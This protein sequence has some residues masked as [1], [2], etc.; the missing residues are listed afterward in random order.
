MKTGARDLEQSAITPASILTNPTC[1]SATLD[2]RSCRTHAPVC[3]VVSHGSNN[4]LYTEQNLLVWFIRLD[5]FFVQSGWIY[6][7]EVLNQM[8]LSYRFNKGIFLRYFKLKSMHEKV[9]CYLPMSQHMYASSLF[10]T[11]HSLSALHYT[12]KFIFLLPNIISTLCAW[13]EFKITSFF[14]LWVCNA[15]RCVLIHKPENVFMMSQ[16]IIPL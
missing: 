11:K 3:Q 13:P 8:D 6:R 14:I 2:T 15:F 9:S 12:M 1:V 16:W 4:T 7:K 10:T 5:S